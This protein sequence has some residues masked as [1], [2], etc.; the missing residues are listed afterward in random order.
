MKNKGFTLIEIIAVIVIMGILLMVVFP[1]TSRIMRSNEEKEYDTYYDIV[2]EGLEKY[3]RTKRNKVGGSQGSGCLDE[4]GATVQTLIDMGYIKEFDQE[5]NVI[6]D[7]PRAFNS[8]LLNGW[9]IDTSKSYANLRIEGN[10]GNISTKLSLVCAV[11]NDD[12]TYGKLLYKK[13]VE[14]SGSCSTS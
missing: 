3:A 11:K 6:C 10:N 2:K 14:V 8:G 12:G 1:A 13:M 4:A 9:G 5:E 7:V